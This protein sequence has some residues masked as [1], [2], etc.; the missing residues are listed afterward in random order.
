MSQAKPHHHHHGSDQD[1]AN[2]GTSAQGGLGTL[3]STTSG[4]SSPSQLAQNLFS[5]IDS[6]GDGSISKS[7][8]E[9]AV[10]SAAGPAC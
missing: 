7:E 4:A 8:L 6:N 2:N 3:L 5:L 1:N 9:Q 10:S